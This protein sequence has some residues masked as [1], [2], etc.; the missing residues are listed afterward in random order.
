MKLKPLVLAAA[1]ALSAGTALAEDFTVSVPLVPAADVAGFFSAAFGTTHVVAGGFTDT[2]TFT[3]GPASGIAEASLITIGFSQA[4]DID[5]IGASLNGSALSLTG[6]GNVQ[7][8]ILAP[9]TYTGPLVLT[10]TGIASPALAVGTAVSASY[11]GTVNVSPVP[12]PGSYALLL[13]GLGVMGFV[14]RRKSR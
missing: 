9:Q 14:A 6:G 1:L 5:F 7:F 11:A 13:A 3:G 4:T 12:E 10:V 8:G 2:W